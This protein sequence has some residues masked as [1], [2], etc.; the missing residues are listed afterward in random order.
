M[1]TQI[2]TIASPGTEIH[3]EL[4]ELFDS[5]PLL[6]RMVS[7]NRLY[8]EDLTRDKHNKIVVD[9]T[10]PH[11]LKDTDYFRKAAIT[12]KRTGRYTNYYPSKAPNSP[13]KQFWD[14]EI[15]RCKEGYVRESDGEWVT[16]YYY[17]YLNY[18]P[19]LK[20]EIIGEWSSDG[21]VQADRV[22]GFPDFWDG[23]YWFYH[24]VDQAEKAGKYGTV[25]KA[26]GK[27][28]SFK[29]A[30][31]LARNYFLFKNSKSF[32]LAAD[33]E[34]LTTDGILDSKTWDIFSFIIGNVGFA[35]KMTITDTVMH[36]KS[37][38]KKTGSS[39]EFGFKSEI[40]G[41]T[42]KNDPDKARGKRGKLVVWEEAGSFPHILKS[43]RLAQKSM[44]DGFRVFGFML[45][46]GT[47]GEEGV[48][49]I[50]LE[51]LFYSSKAYRV[52]AVQNV[53]DRNAEGGNCAFFVPDY[54]NRADCYDKDGNSDVVKACH[55]VLERRLEVKYNSSDASDYAQVKAEEPFT[56]Q[57][58]VMRTE[59]TVFPVNDLKERLAEIIPVK[60]HFI[61]EHYIGNLNWSGDSVV[62]RPKFDIYPIRDYP[63]KGKNREG[64]IE[65]FELPKVTPGNSVPVWGRYIGGVDPV[66]DDEGTSLFSIYIMDLFT[67]TLVAEYTG[68]MNK[69]DLNFEIALKLAVYYNA[70][71]NYE[72]KLKGLFSYFERQNALRFLADTPEILRDMEYVKQKYVTGNKSKGVPPTPAINSWGRRLQAD[73]MMS[74]NEVDPEGKLNLQRIRSI[75]Y[76]K[77]CIQWNIDGN[78]DRVSAGI[79]LF[80]LRASKLKFIESKKNNKETDA[81]YNKDTFFSENYYDMSNLTNFEV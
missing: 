3:S 14:E 25:L 37:G 15:R 49:F 45:A 8:A 69:A 63:Y 59:G 76:I 67:D 64:A 70:E 78:F 7:K 56:P 21:T 2:D 60:E 57:E 18:S 72:N 77:E 81:D 10:N 31:M 23:D 43:W 32:A 24:Y 17:F 4:T 71:I 13:Y 38:Y 80:I 39:G 33:K 26:R 11:I 19:I 73:W 55:Q 44:E 46:F 58:S 40:I 27:G 16:G 41:V 5:V 1:I 79:M 51:S 52:Y 66:D 9:I 62:L 50:G 75:G 20:T 12:F 22:S 28:Y 54:L 74:K 30:S 65:L 35:K 6:N 34:Y 68:R 29:A 53:W 36:K 42:L 61:S 48:D 47:G